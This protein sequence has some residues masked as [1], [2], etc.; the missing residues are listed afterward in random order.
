MSLEL[1]IDGVSVPLVPNTSINLEIESSVF[2]YEVVRGTRSLPFTLPVCRETDELFGFAG[3]L[4][5]AGNLRKSYPAE[6]YAHGSLILQGRFKLTKP[7]NRAYP[8]YL[9]AGAGQIPKEVADLPL[10]SLDMG[11]HQYNYQEYLSDK[12][13]FT[14]LDPAGLYVPDIQFGQLVSFYKFRPWHDG[15]KL[16]L[17]FSR[18]GFSRSYQID[19]NGDLASSLFALAAEFNADAIDK[20]DLAHAVGG[21]FTIIIYGTPATSI[22]IK[23]GSQIGQAFGSFEE[24]GFRRVWERYVDLENTDKAVFPIICNPEFYPK[25]NTVFSGFVNQTVEAG[26]ALDSNLNQ[27]Y[28]PGPHYEQNDFRTR[29]RN[30]HLPALYQNKVLESI[31][32]LAKLNVKS[33]FGTDPDLANLVIMSNVAFDQQIEGQPKQLDPWNL[34]VQFGMIE[35]PTERVSYPGFPYPV[36][37]YKLRYA[38]HLPGLTVGEYLNFLR[39]PFNLGFFFSQRTGEV[40]IIPLRD[41]I[42]AACELDW[43]SRVVPSWAVDAEDEKVYELSFKID[44]TDAI[45]KEDPITKQKDSQLAAFTLAAADPEA[46]TEKIE[47]TLAI[48]PDRAAGIRMVPHA[49]QR[50]NSAS[51]FGGVKTDGTPRLMFWHGLVNDGSGKPYPKASNTTANGKYSLQWGGENGL[52]NT[53]WKDWLAF[54]RRSRRIEIPITLYPEDLSSL[55]L[56]RKVHIRGNDYLIEKVEISVPLR[57]PGKLIAWRV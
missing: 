16:I 35:Q 2:N 20:P 8:G 56:K 30:A 28:G 45:F 47:S 21:C 31:F 52:Y 12:I 1:R 51:L 11:T 48:W 33:V 3:G 32:A 37:P 57:S 34:G 49:L 50:L 46:K 9:V 43:T 42:T 53:W 27:A 18:S 24:Y 54:I 26:S 6:L 40:E 19:F 5:S 29:T 25:E 17:E 36:V 22:K 39:L 44:S 10:R 23:A 41:I 55:N 4:Q 14:E 15:D 38:D 13:F 7:T